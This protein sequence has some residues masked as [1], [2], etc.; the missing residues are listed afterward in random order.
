[1]PIPEV[2]HQYTYLFRYKIPKFKFL[3][4]VSSDYDWRADYT[5]WFVSLPKNIQEQYK[6]DKLIV[7]KLYFFKSN[8]IK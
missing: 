2:K 1:M 3:A 4:V 8:L 7:E 6:H 5:Q